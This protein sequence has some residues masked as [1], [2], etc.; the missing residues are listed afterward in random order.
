MSTPARFEVLRDEIATVLA[1][2]VAAAHKRGAT[3]TLDRLNAAGQ[4]LR[5]APLT[6]VVCG[7]FKRGKSSLLNALLEE[8]PPLF[9]VN[10]RVATSVVTAVSY[11]AEESIDVTLET[12]TGVETRRIARAE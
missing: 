6:V 1:E 11:A 3:A 12:G 2:L 10:A 5:E 9:P 8:Q 4:R 7:E